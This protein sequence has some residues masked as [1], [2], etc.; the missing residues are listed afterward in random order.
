MTNGLDNIL[1]TNGGERQPPEARIGGPI[2]PVPG[3]A[4]AAAAAPLVP[5][6][7][8]AFPQVIPPSGSMAGALA[9]AK[10]KSTIWCF[11]GGALQIL[12]RCLAA[13]AA[14]LSRHIVREVEST[15]RSRGNFCRHLRDGILT[16]SVCLSLSAISRL[17]LKAVESHLLVHVSSGYPGS[18]P[19]SIFM[20]RDGLFLGSRRVDFNAAEPMLRPWEGRF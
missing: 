10:A 16:R 18:P 14:D 20:S 17:N 15:N 6:A 12:P 19:E 2:V 7:A 13:P 4:G 8:K 11:S 3:A 5:V 9:A 1:N